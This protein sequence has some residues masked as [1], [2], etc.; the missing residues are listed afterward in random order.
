MFQGHALPEKV[1]LFLY[2]IS[3]AIKIVIFQYLPT[4]T[5][6]PLPPPPFSDNGYGEV[7]RGWAGQGVSF[8]VNWGLSMTPKHT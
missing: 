1:S 3:L 2:I 5:L 6:A 4:L 8:L 7:R